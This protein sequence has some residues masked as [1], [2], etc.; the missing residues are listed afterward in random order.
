M[1]P[2]ELL[3]TIVGVL[4]V[5]VLA[6]LAARYRAIRRSRTANTAKRTGPVSTLIVLGSGGHTAEMLHI[7]GALNA[8]RYRPR[9]Y[10]CA[11]TDRLSASAAERLEAGRPAA[12]YSV[13]RVQRSRHVH[14]SYVSAVWTTARA[15]LADAVPLLWTQRPGLVL[16][17]GPGTCVPVA[18]A[19]WALRAVGRLPV[20]S[21]VVFVES[22]CRVRSVSLSGRL[23]R[24]LADLFVVQWP[25]LAAGGAG[26]Y[27]GKLM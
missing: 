5:A 19:A 14:Q 11:A 26:T 15:F 17:N 20:D 24:P 27:V 18:V 2:T 6:G 22:F 16:C 13:V 10:V 23:L 21:R 8:Q 7:V 25:E 4:L 1:L 9:V 12:D 3:A